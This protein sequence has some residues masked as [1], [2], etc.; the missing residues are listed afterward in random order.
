[1]AYVVT[2]H[3]DEEPFEDQVKNMT[4]DQLQ[5]AMKAATVDGDYD[6]VLVISIELKRRQNGNKQI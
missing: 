1:M 2:L 4:D 6:K 3:F 5:A